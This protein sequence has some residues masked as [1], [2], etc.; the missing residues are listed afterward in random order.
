MDVEHKCSPCV[1]LRAENGRKIPPELAHAC[2]TEEA[3]EV[4]GEG[5][6]GHT[7]TVV[8]P[9]EQ[10]G[11]LLGL[12]GERMVGEG[13]FQQGGEGTW[14]FLQLLVLLAH[15]LEQRA[16][17]FLSACAE[18]AHCYLVDSSPCVGCAAPFQ[19]HPRFPVFC[20]LPD[21]GPLVS[22][23]AMRGDARAAG[24]LGRQDPGPLQPAKAGSDLAPVW[25]LQS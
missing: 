14:G 16:R 22:T 23:L 17:C 19:S 25:C 18:L 6:Q 12:L 15:L 8:V 4:G 13:F 21:P 5:C 3:S 2:V 10:E 1:V 7:A 9:W 11:W 24:G 20:P